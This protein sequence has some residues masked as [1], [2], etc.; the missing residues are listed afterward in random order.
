MTDYPDHPG[1]RGVSTSVEAANDLAPRLGKLQ[2]LVL[3][4][5]V[6]ACPV[7]LT[8]DELAAKVHMDRWSVQ[9]RTTELKLK[10]LILDS[11]RRRPNVT[12]KKAI[13]WVAA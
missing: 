13:V 1:H 4:A 6:E 12:G 9:P 3:D 2:K 7:G 5:V 10:G 11:G 8:A